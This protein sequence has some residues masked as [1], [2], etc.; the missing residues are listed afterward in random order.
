MLPLHLAHSLTP[1]PHPPSHTPAEC[2]CPW[3][4]HLMITCPTA[5]TF[6]PTL[7]SPKLAL[8]LFPPHL[9]QR[10][11]LLKLLEAALD[12]VLHVLRAPLH[13]AK[14]V[15]HGVVGQ[16][17]TG[18]EGPRLATADGSAQKEKGGRFVFDQKVLVE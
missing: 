1:P 13:S 18:H 6:P 10:A 5:H 15:E 4:P 7:P 16:L 14:H 8:T 3:M 17:E 9:R 2:M 11:L 12:D